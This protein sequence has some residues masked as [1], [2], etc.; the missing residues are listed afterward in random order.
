MERMARE[1]GIVYAAVGPR[2][3][4]EAR[5]SAESARLKCDLPIAAL[6]YNPDD[7]S[8]FDVVMEANPVQAKYGTSYQIQ[9]L[10]MS[11]FDRTLMLDA[12]T[13]VC[14][15]PTPLF[16]ILDNYDFA[17]RRAPAYIDHWFPIYST[18][19]ILARNNEAVQSL[20]NDWLVRF[21]ESEHWSNQHV[22]RD[23]L[24]EAIPAGLR[25]FEF[26]PEVEL[27]LCGIQWLR[28]KVYILHTGHEYKDRF[29]L[30]PQLCN[31]L[32]GVCGRVYIPERGCFK[33]RQGEW[34]SV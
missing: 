33:F 20:C 10:M 15:D 14:Q 2:Y 1:T 24:L 23:A 12:D 25:F 26:G 30:S 11:P 8:A 4:I 31:Q 19:V 13:Y 21:R 16:E 27:K 22:L 9:A 3:L 5:Q 29:E 34:V 18:G 17:L 6:T 7:T 32:G 28:S